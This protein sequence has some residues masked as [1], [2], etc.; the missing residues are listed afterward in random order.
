[1]KQ[2]VHAIFP[3]KFKQPLFDFF[4]ENEKFDLLGYD[5]DIT[6]YTT[7]ILN[8]DTKNYSNTV[9]ISIYDHNDIPFKDLMNETTEL[10]VKVKLARQDLRLIIIFPSFVGE[11][12]EFRENISRLIMAGIYDIHFKGNYGFSDIISFLEDKRVLTDLKQF[13]TN[14]DIPVLMANESN[15]HDER[16]LQ[17]L[18]NEK[19]IKIPETDSQEHRKVSVES[20]VPAVKNEKVETAATIQEEVP[21]QNAEEIE[22]DIQG[23]VKEEVKPTVDNLKSDV[24]QQSSEKEDSDSG[25]KFKKIF[26]RKQSTEVP[27]ETSINKT[28]NPNQNKEIE[29]EKMVVART[30]MTKKIAVIGV[31]KNVGTSF[32]ATNLASFL[33]NAGLDVGVYENPVYEQHRTYLADMFF[34]FDEDEPFKSLPVEIVNKGEFDKRQIYKVKGTSY[35][36]VNYLSSPIIKFE[37]HDLVR[38]INTNS[39][40]IKIMDMGYITEKEMH[41]NDLYNKLSSFDE[42]IIVLSPLP[43]KIIPNAKIFMAFKKELDLL[44]IKN[45]TL[46]NQFNNEVSKNEFKVYNLHKSLVLPSVAAETVTKAMYKQQNVYDY[47][48]EASTLLNEHFINITNSLNLPLEVKAQK[49][50]GKIFNMVLAK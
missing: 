41:N 47:K 28:T 23:V 7:F 18:L 25:R 49:G 15:L 1:M 40:S 14:S 36:P 4:S 22:E 27:K 10:A 45:V 46:L 13:I 12:Y 44:G 20:V 8:K 43:T 3:L 42:V 29:I 31:T 32:V 19:E 50:K 26:S 21:P 11:R 2:A 33:T 48:N 24:L 5:T 35:Y 37:T 9:L 38:Y 17:T 6:N 34:F 16:E 39:H 30:N